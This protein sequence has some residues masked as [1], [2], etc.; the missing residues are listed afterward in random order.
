MS[1]LVVIDDDPVD[2]FVMKHL[3]HGRNYFET[4]TFTTYSSLVTEYI[5]E[6]HDEPDKLPDV[7]FLDLN[8]PGYDGWQF[9]EDMMKMQRDLSKNIGVYV[10]TSSVRVQDMEKANRYPF[11][12]SFLSKPLQPQIIEQIANRQP[13]Y[14]KMNLQ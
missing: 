5:A 11:V 2:H 4:T 7:I 8:M 6:H 12:R 9:L 13:A 14:A 1:K 3:L 10:L